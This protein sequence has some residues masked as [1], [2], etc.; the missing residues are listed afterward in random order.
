MNSLPAR[1]NAPYDRGFVSLAHLPKLSRPFVGAFA[2][3]SG[4]ALGVFPLE[5]GNAYV[6]GR[7]PALA[8]DLPEVAGYGLRELRL[9][10]EPGSRLSRFE[11][12]LIPGP[13]GVRGVSLTAQAVGSHVQPWGAELEDRQLETGYGRELGAITTLWTASSGRPGADSYQLVVVNPIALREQD[14]A[15]RANLAARERLGAQRGGETSTSVPTSPALTEKQVEAI[16]GR[17]GGL[18]MLPPRSE[19]VEATKTNKAETYDRSLEDIAKKVQS[20]R[21]LRASNRRRAIHYLVAQGY[22]PISVVQRKAAELDLDFGY[23]WIAEY[24]HEHMA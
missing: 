8:A 4:Q 3:P 10:G 13:T 2:W 24:V 20:F 18:L 22:L 23:G 5:E 9:L 11:G 7:D 6:Y 21:G 16:V 19:S 12:V 15:Y 17:F 14:R 1:A